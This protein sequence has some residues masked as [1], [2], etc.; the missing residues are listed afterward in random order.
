MCCSELTKTVQFLT[1]GRISL[2]IIFSKDRKEAFGEENNLIII[3][4]EL[5]FSPA[6]KAS[7][8]LLNHSVPTL[9]EVR[10]HIPLFFKVGSYLLKYKIIPEEKS[11]VCPGTC[12]KVTW[13]LITELISQA[14]V[15]HFC[16]ESSFFVMALYWHNGTVMHILKNLSEIFPSVL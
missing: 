14:I 8:I 3:R 2:A 1:R 6:L 7:Y 13:Q 11:N 9:W 5:V 10:C 4:T 15:L 16:M 12:K